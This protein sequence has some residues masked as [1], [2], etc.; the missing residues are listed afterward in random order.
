VTEIA[1]FPVYT[2]TMQKPFYNIQETNGV[3]TFDFL[4]TTTAI[5]TVETTDIQKGTDRI[6]TIDG[7]LVNTAKDQLPKGIYI[8][9]KKKVVIK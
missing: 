9:G 1:S 6:Y 7:R 4:E 8:I 3:I 2:G 5:K